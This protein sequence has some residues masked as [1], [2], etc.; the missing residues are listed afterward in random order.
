[1]NERPLPDEWRNSD[2]LGE[3]I[4]PLLPEHKNTHRFG[5]VRPCALGATAVSGKERLPYEIT[6][7]GLLAVGTAFIISLCLFWYGAESVAA[8]FMRAMAIEVP[9]SIASSSSPFWAILAG[10]SFMG[11]ALGTAI[12]QVFRD[13]RGGAALMGAFV[14]ALA[15]PPIVLILLFELLIVIGIWFGG[16]S[17]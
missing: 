12:G 3:A 11:G 9:E 15:G 17:A 16:L 5:G 4:A 2:D 13:E 6:R 1:M 10:A 7:G 8:P 14:G